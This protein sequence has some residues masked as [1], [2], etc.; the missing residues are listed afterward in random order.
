MNSNQSLY[1]IIDVVERIRRMDRILDAKE[2]EIAAAAAAMEAEVGYKKTVARCQLQ[3]ARVLLNSA[4]T[5]YNDLGASIPAPEELLC[6]YS[7]GR[8]ADLRIKRGDLLR[9]KEGLGQRLAAE[10]EKLKSGPWRRKGAPT[11]PTILEIQSQMANVDLA[12]ARVDAEIADWMKGIRAEE[13]ARAEKRAFN[14]W[15]EDE[16]GEVAPPACVV[17]REREERE[18]FMRTA[19]RLEIVTPAVVKRRATEKRAAAAEAARVAT[20][21]AAWLAEEAKWQARQKRAAAKQ[22]EFYARLIAANKRTVAMRQAAAAEAPQLVV[23][24]CA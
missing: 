4:I 1:E 8:I 6:G 9:D 10:E 11:P 14:A 17:E 23:E 20:E 19:V 15:M 2:A 18:E 21:E 16:T 24:E 13:E 22:Q 3:Y 5:E 7:I 12:V